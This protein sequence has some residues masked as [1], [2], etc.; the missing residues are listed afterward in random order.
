M[1]FPVIIGVGITVAALTAKAVTRSV[2]RYRRLTPQMIATLNKLRL[3]HHFSDSLSK[4][5]GKATHLRYLTSRFDNRGFE[6]TMTEREALLVLGIEAN[7]ISGL[8]KDNLRQRYRK[9]MIMN[10]PDKNGSVYL[11]QKIN[12]AKEVL[13]HSYMFRK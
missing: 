7:D 3:E 12:Q 2:G 10:H 1:V 13:E 5:D 9:L 8:T 6:H 11:S 4:Q